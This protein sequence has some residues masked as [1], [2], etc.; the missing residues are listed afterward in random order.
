VLVDEKLAR[1]GTIPTLSELQVAV[2]RA[3]EAKG[4]V[5]KENRNAS[6]QRVQPIEERVGLAVH[7]TQE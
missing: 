5:V 3:F 2:R 4:I 7:N 1:Q 6:L